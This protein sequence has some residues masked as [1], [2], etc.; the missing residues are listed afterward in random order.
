M[1]DNSILLLEYFI[2]WIVILSLIAADYQ[3]QK[4]N[5]QS[6]PTPPEER[7]IHPD[8]TKRPPIHVA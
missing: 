8:T 2:I 5:V 3:C 7:P 1:S 4:S 6:L